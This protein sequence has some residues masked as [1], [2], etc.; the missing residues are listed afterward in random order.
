[1]TIDV[2][3]VNDARMRSPTRPPSPR[4]ARSRPAS[5]S[6][7]ARARPTKPARPDRHRRDRGPPRHGQHRLDDHDLHPGRRLQRAGQ[8][9]LHDHRRRHDQRRPIQEQHGHRDGH[10][11][12]RQRRPGRHQQD[13]DHAGRHGLH[14]HARPTSASPIPTTARPTTCWPSRSRRCRRPARSTDNGVAVVRPASSSRWPTSPPACSSSRRPPTPT[15][16]PTPASP[17]RSR[18][19][20]ARAN[21]GV[22]LDPSANTIT[23]NVTAVNDAPAG[24][25]KTVTTLEDTA[26][27]FTAADFGFT[28][29]NDT[30]GQHPAGRQDHHAADRRHA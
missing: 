1:M 23:V 2:S 20:A 10:R 18:T 19:T 24:T 7:T 30:P 13:R 11:H 16:R 12:R 25:D 27:T 4:T 22:D 14:V 21:G 26:Y 28:D 15:A 5:W 3:E 6:T 9:H 29:P 8:L 17:S